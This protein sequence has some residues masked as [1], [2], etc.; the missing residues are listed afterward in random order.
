M[1]NNK[2]IMK[3][4]SIEIKNIINF[5]INKK[6]DLKINVT[7]L[8]LDLNN[9]ID[10]KKLLSHINV[11]KKELENIL[12]T[13]KN[14]NN[15]EALLK[16]NNSHNIIIINTSFDTSIKKLYH[17]L[18]VNT[19]RNINLL[20]IYPKNIITKTKLLGIIGSLFKNIYNDVK[21]KNNNYY[22]NFMN[23]DLIK[24]KDITEL[25]NIH[26]VINVTNNNQSI[27]NN[28]R[29]NY[30]KEK[31]PILL[32]VHNNNSK[33]KNI[34]D[35][36]TKSLKQF[37]KLHS[38]SNTNKSINSKVLSNN[39][40]HLLYLLKK[41][42]YI[43]DNIKDKINYKDAMHLKLILGNKNNITCQTKY[44]HKLIP[45]L[46]S[47]GYNVNTIN[48]TNNKSH[49]IIELNN[50]NHSKQEN[51]RTLLNELIFNIILNI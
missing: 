21:I 44:K 3:K 30:K 14:D 32:S 27:N 38:V 7:Y 41:D 40:N 37:N 25:I 28:M 42:K 36:K 24:D 45:I 5:S 51:I 23:N 6:L 16:I 50:T 1:I 22:I 17:S 33:T 19:I 11:N 10:Y 15:N 34:S 26:K 35:N 49:I 8:L 2:Y 4:N 47:N 29:S 46:N 31:K 12:N 20:F 13:M 9:K 18:I 48:T 39:I 43:V